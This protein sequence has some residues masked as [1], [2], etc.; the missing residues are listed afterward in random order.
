[1]YAQNGKKEPGRAFGDEWAE[2]GGGRVLAAIPY[3]YRWRRSVLSQVAPT[4]FGQ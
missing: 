3:R 2:F 1:L 4:V